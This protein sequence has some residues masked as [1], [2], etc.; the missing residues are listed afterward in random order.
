MANSAWSEQWLAFWKTRVGFTFGEF[1]F[2]HSLQ[3]WINDG[4]MVVF[5]FVVG[6][7]VKR[8]MVTGELRDL[9][10]A[11]LPVAAAIGGMVVPAAV[12]LAVSS[13][14]PGQSGWGIPMATD[15]AFVVGCMAVLGSRMPH[16]MRVTVLGLAIVD[17]IGAILVIAFG[18]TDHVSLGMLLLG[19]GG[20]L[21]TTWLAR[22]GARSFLVYI[23]LGHI[24]WFGIHESGIHA[25]IA[26]VIL[27]LLTPAR[28]H[29]SESTF[30]GWLGSASDLLHGGEWSKQNH[31]AVQLREFQRA[32]RET[33]SPLEYLEGT[34]HPWVGFCVVPLFALANAG[35]PLEIGQLGN[36]VAV[37]CMAGL[38]IGK[39]VGILLA[40][41]LA[42]RLSLGKLPEGITWPAMI[43]AACLAG[44]G[45]TMSMF[46]AGLAELGDYLDAAKLGILCG[47]AVAAV[48]GLAILWIVLPKKA[49][50]AGDETRSA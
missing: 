14:H 35:V 5:F 44:I 8:E 22:L 17:D 26:G 31:R 27:G 2:V 39:P 28:P 20:I 6:L 3:H 37:A 32:A 36:V 7:E 43:G 50:G 23:V 9:K 18:Y 41:W 13:G 33:I 25:T 49:V 21:L 11:T 47:S 12:Y 46:I 38:V 1:T 19:A 15:I 16:I 42:V 40:S 30:A 34:L 24:I 48:M 45:F 29:L 10:R 4:L